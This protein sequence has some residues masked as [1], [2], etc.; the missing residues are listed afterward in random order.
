[1]S[2]MIKTENSLY[3][4]HMKCFFISNE[5]KVPDNLI[6]NKYVKDIFEE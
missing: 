1:M 4:L 6:G 5:Y 2:R 3:S